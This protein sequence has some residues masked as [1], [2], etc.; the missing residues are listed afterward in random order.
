[1]RALTRARI[2]VTGAN[3][4]IGRVV[5]E[6]ALLRPDVEVVA[7][8]RSAAAAA[9][10]PVLPEGRG[11]V[12]QIDYAV[13]A[14]LVGA[15]RGV[16]GLIH[17]PGLLIERPDSTYEIANVA[18]TRAAVEAARKAR[19]GKLVLLSACGADPRSRNRFWSTKGRAEQ[20]VAQSGLPYTIVRCGLVLG[21][22]SHGDAAL[23]RDVR[24][25]WCV[26]LGGGVSREQ[27]L[28]ARDL[29]DAL[30]NAACDPARARDAL[31][32]LAGPQSV[33]RRELARRAAALAGRSMRIAPLPVWLARLGAA[34]RQR[35]QGPGA[36]LS[37]DAIE[38]LASDV[39]C[40]SRAAAAALG[41]ELRPLDETLRASLDLGK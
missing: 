12:A 1:L 37:P 33:P 25:G 20:L 36:G 14:T 41:I 29:A 2:A 5:I 27:P 30:L 38:V 21:C 19:V 17:L 31:L 15:L 10:L 34:A 18:A 26:L 3:G 11:S 28:D 4:A 24:R 35:L 40:D 22:R 8:V 32:E 23:A 13:P 16:Q 9:Q 7:A 39:R 6:R